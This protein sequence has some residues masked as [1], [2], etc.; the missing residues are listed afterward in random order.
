MFKNFL[1]LFKEYFSMK[2]DAEE[3][4]AASQARKT[5]NYTW[6]DSQFA[7]FMMQIMQNLEPR[8]YEK[9][10]LIFFESEEVEEVLFVCQGEVSQLIPS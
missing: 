10:E 3:T 4:Q 9:N 7:A 6:E 8:K 2:R 1:Y 5:K